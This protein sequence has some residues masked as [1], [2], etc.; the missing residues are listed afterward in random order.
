MSTH[1]IG[2][3]VLIVGA[4]ERGP[5]K[6]QPAFS[7]EMDADLRFSNATHLIPIS[8]QLMLAA[9]PTHER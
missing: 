2:N 8:A 4:D 1:D 7:W 3:K 6:L 5:P 9:Q